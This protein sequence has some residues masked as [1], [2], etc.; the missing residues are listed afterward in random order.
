MLGPQK[1]RRF[2]RQLLVS[3]ENLVPA[4]NFYRYLDAKLDLLRKRFLYAA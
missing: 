4:N 3:L 2:D 1:Q